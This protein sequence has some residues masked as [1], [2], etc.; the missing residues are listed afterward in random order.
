MWV[1]TALKPPQS[2]RLFSRYA[3]ERQVT[4]ALRD[5]SSF[6]GTLL[7][8]QGLEECGCPLPVASAPE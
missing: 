4:A 5:G 8:P 6:M 3:E 2:R 1:M 7:L